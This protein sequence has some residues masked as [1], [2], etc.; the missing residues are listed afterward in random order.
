MFARAGLSRHFP[1]MLNRFYSYPGFPGFPGFIGNPA[2][3]PEEDWTA[4]AGFEWKSPSI[5]A[6]LQAYGQFAQDAQVRAPLDSQNDTELN[7]GNARIG[8]LLG[9]VQLQVLPW[10]DLGCNGTLSSSLLSA[11]SLAFPGQPAELAVF[12]AGAHGAAELAGGGH[13]WDLRIFERISS[14][15]VADA[16]GARL[17]SYHE[18]DLELRAR[19]EAGWLAVARADDLSDQRPELVLGY[20]S[21]GRTISLLV[22]RQL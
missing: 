1:S 13:R 6:G 10:L 20:P 21:F 7:L 12:F 11:T 22:S 4:T 19:F 5:Q 2:L 3:Q 14:D 15:S 17:P 18:E 8:S 9:R 16:S